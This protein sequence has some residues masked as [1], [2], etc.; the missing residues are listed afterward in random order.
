[1]DGGTEGLVLS[2]ER[3]DGNGYDGDRYAE[4]YDAWYADRPETAAA[5]A[6]LRGLCP[7]GTAL[8]LGVGTGR[9]AVPLATDGPAVTGVDTSPQMLRRLASKAGDAPVTGVLGDMATLALPGPFDLVYVA[10]SSLFLLTSQEAQVCCFARVASL[11]GPDGLFVVE[12]F[13]PD[14]TRYQRNQ[15]ISVEDLSAPSVRFELAQHDPANQTITAVRV[16]L[17]ASGTQLFPYR[18]R[19]ATPAE[20]D[21]MAQLAGLELRER[22]GGFDRRPFSGDSAVHVSIYSPARVGAR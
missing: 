1:L 16:V 20:L 3:D 14:A 19:Y 10:F 4:V 12:A 18:V 21:L 11:L 15:N 22:F 17:D 6:F 13:V 5:V 9:L 8:E 2:P 7:A